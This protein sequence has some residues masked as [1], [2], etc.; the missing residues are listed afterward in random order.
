MSETRTPDDTLRLTDEGLELPSFLRG[1]VGTFTIRTPNIDG[2]LE[3][4]SHGMPDTEFY[5]GP[6][7]AYP[8][9]GDY[10]SELGEGMIAISTPSHPEMTYEIV[11]ERTDEEEV[12]A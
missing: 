11:D 5:D 3:T 12:P 8:D 2:T 4:S 6:I 1:Y 10:N 9:E 7:A